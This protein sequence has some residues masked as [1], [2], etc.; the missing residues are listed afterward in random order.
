M[1]KK[2]LKKFGT[3]WNKKLSG[4]SE[5]KKVSRDPNILYEAACRSD[6]AA[7]GD[8]MHHLHQIF[9]ARIGSDWSGGFKSHVID[10]CNTVVL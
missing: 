6:T 4:K 10:G 9:I 1:K 2:N 7:V 8:N 5:K 3:N